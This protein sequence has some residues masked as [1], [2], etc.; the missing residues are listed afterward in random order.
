MSR[1]RA[2]LAGFELKGRQPSSLDSEESLD[3]L[4]ELAASAGAIVAGRMIQ[5]RERV[6]AATLIGSGKGR[7]LAAAIASADADT[8]VFDRD[9]TPTQQRNLEK[10]LGVKVLDRTQLI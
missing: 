9:L 6:D 8:V 7:E 3:E 1:E 10:E 2:I 5:S 4:A